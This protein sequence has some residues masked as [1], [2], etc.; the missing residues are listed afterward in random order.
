MVFATC[1]GIMALVPGAA[2]RADALRWWDLGLTLALAVL[3][4]VATEQPDLVVLAVPAGIA[5][6]WSSSASSCCCSGPPRRRR[7]VPENIRTGP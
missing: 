3:A 7:P 5:A 1:T 2:A 6:W 4:A